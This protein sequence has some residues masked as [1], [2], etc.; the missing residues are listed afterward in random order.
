MHLR[1]LLALSLLVPALGCP[2]SN[3]VSRVNSSPS[4]TVVSP[5]PD[6]E[7]RQGEGDITL[8]AEV[9]DSYDAPGDLVVTWTIDEEAPVAVDA[10]SAGAVSLSL[11]PDG[12]SLGDHE[13]VV[14]VVD[15]DGDQGTAGV[16]F[17]V[18][19]PF[20]VPSVEITAPDEGTSVAPGIDLAFRGEASDSTTPASDLVFV[21]E[22]D[23]DGVIEGA[24]SAN[25]ES[26]VLTDSLSVGSHVVSLKV[27]DLD[28]EVGQDTVTVTVFDDV[29]AQPGDLVFSEFMVN[30]QVV[31]D[32]VGEWV[33][34]Y[35]TSGLP[36]D[37]TGYRFH[38]DDN[39]SFILEGPLVAAP[40]D[41]VV[42]CANT[43]PNVNGGVPCDGWFLRDPSGNGL[44]LANNPDELVLSRPDGV[45][46][47]WVH[48]EDEWF[49]AGAA[50]GV[51]PSQLEGGANDYAEAWCVQTSITTSGGE[52]GT[53]GA[54][55]DVC[56]E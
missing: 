43:D 11:S 2:D 49:Q 35:N 26:L 37:L 22:S 50:S 3:R 13:A 36:I 44:A 17:V 4:V 34:L 7:F 6:Q 24:I 18:L 29:I 5:T 30:P 10:D 21:W 1:V 19:G 39:D 47:D 46:I 48:Y 31:E 55:N 8:L 9:A 53:P 23:L 27:T 51:S 20:G 16:R 40:N 32:E 33:E 38:D 12:L 25:G 41:Y 42:L 54:A 14:T 52:P 28:G 56:A 15:T 45:E